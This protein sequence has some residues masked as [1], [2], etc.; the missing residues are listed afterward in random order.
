MRN[1][2]YLL[3]GESLSPKYRHSASKIFATFRYVCQRTWDLQDMCVFTG[4]CCYAPGK[5]HFGC[6]RYHRHNFRQNES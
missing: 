2:P 4:E 6:Y 5:H 1:L 3:I